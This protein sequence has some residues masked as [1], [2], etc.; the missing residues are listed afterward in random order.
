M[1]TTRTAKIGWQAA[2]TDSTGTEKKMVGET[3]ENKGW[4]TTVGTTAATVTT[5]W[6][7]VPTNAVAG[8]AAKEHSQ[9]EWR[10]GGSWG[11]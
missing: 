6:A 1:G 4:S 7:A 10:T 11:M 9:Q 2:T 8:A 5:R 3:A